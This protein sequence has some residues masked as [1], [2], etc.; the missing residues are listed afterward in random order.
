MRGKIL[1]NV[2]F[3]EGVVG[4]KGGDF[5]CDGVCSV[6]NEW[7]EGTPK[8][9]LRIVA[10]LRSQNTAKQ[11]LTVPPVGM[12]AGRVGMTFWWLR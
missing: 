5:A 12:T 11:S 10:R 8:L 4:K 6:D 3:V 7:F 9:S 1:G 2:G